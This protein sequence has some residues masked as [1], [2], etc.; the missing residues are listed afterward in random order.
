MIDLKDLREKPDV[1][2]RGADRKQMAVDIDALWENHQNADG[3]IT[4]PAALRPYMH[5]MERIG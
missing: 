3:S 5:G 2:R 4:I 1:Y